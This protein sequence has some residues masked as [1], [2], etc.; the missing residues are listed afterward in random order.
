MVAHRG[1]PRAAEAPSDTA[2]VERLRTTFSGWA[3]C[4]WVAT[5]AYAVVLSAESIYLHRSFRSGF[6]LAVFSQGAW[7]LG[8]LQTPLLGVFGGTALG[9]HVQPGIVLLAPFAWWG[10]GVTGLLVVQSAALALMAPVLFSLAR[11]AGATPFLAAVPAMLWLLSPWTMSVNTA[12]FH[13]TVIVPALLGLG[14]LAARRGD[15]FMLFATAALA[16]SFKEDT[17]LVYVVLGL[18]LLWR[19]TAAWE[20]LSRSQRLRTSPSRSP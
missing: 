13:P 9:G 20:G 3:A 4:V 15:A 8:H 6:D 12:E 11:Q 17:A 14:V 5:L 10:S 18:L 19:A 1:R 7:L 16:V 2:P